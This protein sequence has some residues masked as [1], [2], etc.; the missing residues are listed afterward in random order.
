MLGLVGDIG[1]TNARFALVDDVGGRLSITEPGAYPTKDHSSPE[2]TIEAYLEETGAPRPDKAVLAV[3]GPVTNGAMHFTNL[4]WEVSEV[5]L[6]SVGGFKAARLLNDFEAQALAAPRL[7]PAKLQVLGPELPRPQE[8]TLVILGPGTGFGVAG[9][10]RHGGME[11]VL[12]T[13]GGHISFAPTDDFEVEIWRRFAKAR[14]R[15]S[16]ERVLSGSGLHELYQAIGDIE[17]QAASLPDA[18]AVQTAAESGD[19]L[20]AHTVDRFCRILGSTAG[21]FALA[22]GARAGVYVTGGVAEKLASQLAQGGFRERFD[23]K[24]RFETYM[25]AIPTLL[26]TDPYAALVGAASQLSALG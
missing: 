17:G 4:N 19:V 25:K 6:T 1:G 8:G 18:K 23:A 7:D 21:D 15:I 16:V 11:A 26:V 5:R 13:E 24:G 14:E 12:S 9:L 22:M 20:A 10:V 3:A 2:D